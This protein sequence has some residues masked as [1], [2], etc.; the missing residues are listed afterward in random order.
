MSAQNSSKKTSYKL[1]WEKVSKYEKEDLPQSAA[2]EVEVILKKAIAENNQMQAIKALIH[3]NKYEV[4]IDRE[5]NLNIFSDL[6]KMLT[7]TSNPCEKALLHSMLAELYNDYYNSNRWKINGR[8]KLYDYIPDDMKEWSSNIFTDKIIEHLETSV[9]DKDILLKCT[10]LSYGDII[11]QGEDSRIYEPTLYDFLMKRAI[12]SAGRLNQLNDAIPNKS[13]MVPASKFVEIDIEKNDNNIVYLYYQQ[14]FESLL[15]RNMTSTI[16]LNELSKLA[17]INNRSYI[18]RESDNLAF[19]YKLDSIYGNNETSVEITDAIID[20]LKYQGNLTSE[21]EKTIYDL[22]KTTIAKYPDYKRISIIKNK[23]S[24]AERP[25]LNIKG[26]SLY[27]PN[28]DIIFDAKVRNIP[29]F[30]KT[31]AF[32]LYKKDG[33]KQS[34]V[35]T[36]PFDF[37]T[38]TAYATEP[39]K[40]N[41]GELEAGKYTFV[42][43]TTIKNDDD[44]TQ[45]ISSSIDFD[46]SRMATFA[47]QSAKNE[48]ETYV[49]D[50]ITGAPIENATVDLFRSAPDS[51]EKFKSTKTDKNG[52]ALFQGISEFSSSSYFSGYYNIT[53]AD[54]DCLQRNDI[55]TQYYNNPSYKSDYK[56]GGEVFTVNL[57]T[58]RNIYRPGQTIYFKSIIATYD[59]KLRPSY[60]CTVVLYNAN[61]EEIENKTL[62][63]NEFGS[64]AGEFIIPSSGL[65]GIYRIA[66]KTGSSELTSVA[67]RV[68]EYKRP[69]FEI[70]FDKVE[71][72]CTFGQEVTMKG[73]AK[74][75]SGVNIQNTTVNYIV[76][77]NQLMSRWGWGYRTGEQIDAGNVETKEDG[78]FEITFIPTANDESNLQRGNMY[79]FEINAVITDANGETQS[80]TNSITVGNRS[81]LVSV[82][83]ATQIERA[84]TSQISISA[85]NLNGQN[86]ETSGS[87]EIY[88]L[89]ENDSIQ[90]KVLDGTFKTG[91]QKDLRSRINKLTSGKYRIQ[92]K[93]LDSKEQE[94]E[95][96]S[97][98]ILFSYDDKTPPIK[99]GTWLVKKKTTFAPGKDAEI[100]FGVPGNTT[101]AYY[102]IYNNDSTLIRENFTLDGT[103]KLLSIPY[104]EAY[105][106]RVFLSLF[107]LKDDQFYIEHV[108]LVKEEEPRDSKLEIKLDVFRDKLRPGQ[109]EKWTIS[110][111]D[112]NKKPALAEVLASMYDISLDKLSGG[113][114]H[115]DFHL[116][117]NFTDIRNIYFNSTTARYRS[118]YFRSFN[119]GLEYEWI[120][121]K[122]FS[123]DKLDWYGFDLNYPALYVNKDESSTAYG[124]D[125]AELKNHK[126][127]LQESAAAPM[128]RH[129]FTPPAIAKD[130]RDGYETT[131][132]PEGG[133]VPQIRK[134]FNE[135]AFFYPFLQT[136]KK[137][138]T[139]I[140]FTVPESNTTWRFRALA[141]DKELRVGYIENLVMSHKEL[142]VTPNMPRFVREGDK[143]NIS[144]KISNLSDKDISGKVRIEFFD[145]VTDNIIDLKIKDKEQSFTV[146]KEASSSANWTFDIP[147]DIQLL[148]CRIVAANK[149]FSDGEQHVL[150]VLSNRMLVTESMTVDMNKAGESTFTF[151]KFKDNKSTSLSNY[152]LTFEYTDN[153]AWYAIQALPTMSNP[154]N[155]NAINWF[156][157]YYVNSLGASIIK[158]YPRVA[159]MIDAWK[160]QGGSKDTFVS[161]LQKDEELKTVLLQES[162]WV[163][164]AKTETEQMQRLSLLFDANNSKQLTE[165]AT[166]KLQELQDDLGGWR[167]YKGMYPSRSITQYILYGYAQL[168]GKGVEYPQEVKEMQIHALNFVDKELLKDYT[169]LQ[170]DN[171]EWKAI[172]NISLS[173]LEYLYLRSFYRDIPISRETREA[174]RFY[175]SVVSKYWRNLDLYERSL[176]VILLKK[177][178]D[179]ELA[180]TITQTIRERS[181]TNDKMGMYWPNIK[182][183]TFLSMSGIATHTFL[184]DALKENGATTAEMDL[185]KQWLIKQKQTQ[186]WET[187]HASIEAINA[188]LTTGSDWFTA[189]N[190]AASIKVGKEIV[191]PENKE[192]GT[193][194]VKQSWDKAAINSNMATVTIDRK[195]SQPAYGALYWQYY[196]DLDKLSGAKTDELSVSKQLFKENISADG[197]GLVSITEDSP[198]QVGDKV[199]VRI[200]VH[201]GTAMEF[202]HLKDMRAPCLEPTQVLSGTQWQ[203]DVLYY[204]ETKDASTNYFFDR[205]PKGT[206]VFEYPVYVNRTGEYSNGTTTIQCLYAPEFVSHTQGIKVTVK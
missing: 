101:Y 154:T 164:E 198:L 56:G 143:T 165:K 43:K 40:L 161:K 121:V 111:K 202:V 51:W 2:K 74:S 138:E 34:L 98:F 22:C 72:T 6:Q 81:M 99:K 141:H 70:T 92:I 35:K 60:P 205:M 86:I 149:S 59:N 153:P 152:R 199:V 155:E 85:M 66:V 169:T 8:S 167:W 52:F 146:A 100:I 42:Y 196:E 188:L 93:A 128:G 71:K 126:V 184:M 203:N 69:T 182:E 125:I 177:N 17:E 171:K 5:N 124:I 53:L 37:T 116:P 58:D 48:Y 130:N 151:D 4:I 95:D 189:S 14:Y 191:S 50:R 175:T 132:S 75:F 119:L 65:Q 197:K 181:V 140:S 162:P 115:W 104:S 84:D 133:S 106:D 68:E 64:I 91:V 134:N 110:I 39:R 38:S 118:D 136:N 96:K 12:K 10:T 183:H 30:E 23:L 27:Y 150:S 120:S 127:V 109:E 112:K 103:N 67:V 172:E 20:A 47:R 78:S 137:G 36:I 49:V 13:Y 158:Q 166:T 94:V 44:K 139:L 147:T 31:P 148:G 79:S 179:K 11:E 200:T 90:S 129:K 29:S 192:L 26:E 15:S 190:D 62:I 193:E 18:F 187:T 63:S 176:L 117:M 206:Y 80:G 108:Q 82:D 3:K 7:Q 173:Q 21:I 9:K 157:S 135:T 73:Y 41:V 46:V 159:A 83:I 45:E 97:D 87:Y 19:L 88:T 107:Y 102:Q 178:G 33:E 55:R 114:S 61:G 204:S 174:E 24:E 194:Y 32:L 25:I 113:N 131:P 156:A 170:K 144:T 57:F 160:K 163:L 201:V 168:Q 186:A 195:S 1:N 89:N 145:P 76:T 28:T 185:M 122:S 16:I 77:R 105:D 54:G 123:F 180:S 142:M